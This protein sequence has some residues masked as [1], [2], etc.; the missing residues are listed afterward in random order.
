MDGGQSG[1]LP[2]EVPGR[3]GQHDHQQHEAAGEIRGQRP[4]GGLGG[5]AQRWGRDF[6]HAENPTKPRATRPASVAVPAAGLPYGGGQLSRGPVQRGQ[7]RSHLIGGQP[8]GQRDVRAP[9]AVAELAIRV[10]VTELG[11]LLLEIDQGGRDRH[12]P[13]QHVRAAAR[14][15][16]HQ[17]A[18]HH[19]E[20]QRAEQARQR[21]VGLGRDGVP[22][23]QRQVRSVVRAGRGPARGGQ[24]GV[25]QSIPL[26]PDLSVRRRVQ[27]QLHRLR[28]GSPSGAS[29]PDAAF[30]SAIGRTS[31]VRSVDRQTAS[32]VRDCASP[33]IKKGA[34]RRPRRRR[35][36]RG[37]S[38]TS[39]RAASASTRRRSARARPA[40]TA[41]RPP[42]GRRH[43]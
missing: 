23:P 10:R 19:L 22:G 29:G 26:R 7:R 34:G 21:G 32:Q 31:V 30:L 5:A 27:Q 20:I 25:A 8:P 39:G 1:R 9:P 15:E 3:I 41:G 13:D 6:G 11:H 12:L 38:W 4:L 18:D 36:T 35:P 17:A 14:S 28:H 24:S 43:R 33:K 40:T 2:V 16:E 42:T 37:R